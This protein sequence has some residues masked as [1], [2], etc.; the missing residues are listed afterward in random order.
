[1]YI[2][3]TTTKNQVLFEREQILTFFI[4][5]PSE[6]KSRFMVHYMTSYNVA[7]TIYRMEFYYILCMTVYKTMIN[8]LL[9]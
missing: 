9:A 4:S 1:M 7:M 8:V 5:S 2:K 6:S 3:I